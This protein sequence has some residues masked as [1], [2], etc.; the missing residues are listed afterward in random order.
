MPDTMFD[1]AIITN[2]VH[3]ASRAPSLHNTQPWRWVADHGA[4]AVLRWT[5]PLSA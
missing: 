5:A 2:A 1:S 3:L 4:D